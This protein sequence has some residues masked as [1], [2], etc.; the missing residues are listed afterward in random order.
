[1]GHVD[2]GKTTLVE[3]LSG[4]WT[5]THSEELKR[6]ITIRL[7]YADA[8]LRKCPSCK[9][10][11]CYTTN[12]KCPEHNEETEVLRTVSFVD[13]P[14]HETLMANVLSG[15][16]IMDGALLLISAD[17]KCPQPQTKEHLAAL[18]IIGVENIVIVQNKIDLVSEERAK[19]SYK[20]IKE[21]VEGTVAEGCPIIPVS[22]QHGSNIDHLIKNIQENI[23][24]PEKEKEADPKMLVARSFDINKP[25]TTPKDLKGGVVGG[26]IVKGKL[27][28]GDEI[29]L[30][31]GIRSNKKWKK[32][33]AK[34]E[35]IMHGNEKVEEGKP[36]G[37]LAIETSLDPSL[38]KS[39]G[40]AGN[41]LGKKGELPEVYRSLEIEVNLMDRV[42]GSEDMK[43]IENIKKKEPLMLN[44]GTAKS[45][46]V[47][48]QAGKNIKVDLKIPVC[49]EEGERIS[50][51]RRIG[52]RWRLIGYGIIKGGKNKEN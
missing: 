34:I 35:G 30:R 29:E 31:P 23:P 8:D 38:A 25:G 39:D 45:T 21:F 41:V 51:S 3:A 36:G 11:K 2:S 13:A 12:K 52:T 42:V 20:E 24:T 18:D 10:P 4:K 7:G 50:I 48:T 43:K 19:E 17:E 27:E 33:R 47:V 16:A 14:G 46:G 28:V 22:A 44:V 26:S 9:E 40:L 37:L 1:M 6:G 15:A 32:A 49:A 5:D